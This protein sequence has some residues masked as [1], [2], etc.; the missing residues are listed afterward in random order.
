[1]Q[2]Q[3]DEW[4]RE[5]FNQRLVSRLAEAGDV[6]VGARIIEEP[7]VPDNPVWPKEK[8]IM[9]VGGMVGLLLGFA[10]GLFS[11]H[12]QRKREVVEW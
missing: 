8:L 7:L 4:R 10:L 5:L 3:A 12:R 11:L 9:A 1:M 6:G 2:A